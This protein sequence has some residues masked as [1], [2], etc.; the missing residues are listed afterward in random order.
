M[1]KDVVFGAY[2]IIQA[3]GKQ[4]QA[5][6]GKTLSIER[7]E[8]NEG[9]LVTFEHVL[10]RKTADGTVEIGTPFLKIPVRASIV[11]HMRDPK[12]VAFRFKRRKKVRVKKGHR[13]HKTIVR[14]ES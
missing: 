6:P 7:V 11:K 12:I 14:I 13:Q 2:A 1:Q 9:D 4:Y 3:G 8:G 5:I 10:L